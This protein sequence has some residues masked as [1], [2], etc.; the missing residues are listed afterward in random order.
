MNEEAAPKK[1]K[2]KKVIRW[3]FLSWAIVSTAWMA[4]SFR[5]QNV[6]ESVLKASPKVGVIETDEFLEFSPSHPRATALMFICGSGVEA[7]AY[8]PLLRPIADDGYTVTIVK[9]PFRFAPLESHKQGALERVRK[10]IGS[11]SSNLQWVVSGHSLGAALACRVAQSADSHV[12]AMVLLGTTHPKED[13][14]SRLAI[15]VTKVV[16]TNDGVAP[17]AKVEANKSLLP[18]STKWVTIVGGNHSQ[19]GNYGHQLMDGKATISRDE[20]QG[21]ARNALLERLRELD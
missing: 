11:H 10:A 5:T 13:D 8:A 21:I 15:H 16:A 20:Q 12:K 3:L 9:L 14:L 7:D 6:P 4:N 1:G 19:F 18:P 17:M 2:A